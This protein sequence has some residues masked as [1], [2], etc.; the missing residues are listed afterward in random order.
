MTLRHALTKLG[1]LTCFFTIP[2]PHCERKCSEARF[3]N[4][5]TALGALTIGSC[6]ATR[7]VIERGPR[8]RR[9]PPGYRCQSESLGL[10]ASFLQF[11]FR[12]QPI[13]DVASRI[14]SSLFEQFVRTEGDL[15]PRGEFNTL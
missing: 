7:A 9:R 14:A 10:L 2:A 3:G 8:T 15:V 13:V 5:V 12:R 6:D 1:C 11:A 4:L